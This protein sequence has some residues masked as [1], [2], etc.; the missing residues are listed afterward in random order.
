MARARGKL[1]TKSA[2]TPKRGERRNAD[3][4]GRSRNPIAYIYGTRAAVMRLSGFLAGDFL[5]LDK[6]LWHTCMLRHRRMMTILS[7]KY[8]F[9]YIYLQRFRRFLAIN[10]LP[11]KAATTTTTTTRSRYISGDGIGRSGQIKLD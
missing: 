11:P 8:N 1:C 6:D 9:N 2:V 7:V 10:P 4:P 3:H 5:E